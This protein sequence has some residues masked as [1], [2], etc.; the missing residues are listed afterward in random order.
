MIKEQAAIVVAVIKNQEGKILV[1][2]RKEPDIPE[3]D[4]KWEFVGG[5]IEFL[6]TPEDAVI[7]ETKEESGLD[8]VIKRLLPKI[9]Q[10]HWISKQGTE[11]HIILISYECEVVGGT[12]HT[13]NF[14]EK[15]SELKFIN[16]DELANLETLPMTNE[17]AALLNT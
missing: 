17:I 1:A 12:L 13:E 3:A 5:H 14:D 16:P 15:I 10:N 9:Y 11:Q 7:R 6:E 2:K 4:G 8:V